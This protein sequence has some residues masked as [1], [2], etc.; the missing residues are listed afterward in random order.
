MDCP[1]PWMCCQLLGRTRARCGACGRLSSPYTNID[2]GRRINEEYRR[3]EGGENRARGITCRSGTVDGCGRQ[4]R[5]A[6]SSA[7]N[8]SSL[9]LF[10]TNSN[11]TSKGVLV[12]TLNPRLVSSS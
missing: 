6:S 5:H 1:L 10:F 2:I 12:M 7:T 9:L 8:S 3:L 4:E 11:C